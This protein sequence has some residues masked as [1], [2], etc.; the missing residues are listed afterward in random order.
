MTP[1]HAVVLPRPLRNTGWFAAKALAIKQKYALSVNPAERDA[2]ASMLASDS[3]RT[4]TC[5]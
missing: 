4:V 1:G 5:N 2:L 3:S